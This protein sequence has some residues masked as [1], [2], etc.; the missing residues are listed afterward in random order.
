MHC[1]SM[2]RMSVNVESVKSF[3][4]TYWCKYP[5]GSSYRQFQAKECT[6]KRS[7]EMKISDFNG[8]SSHIFKEYE[9]HD[10]FA[11]SWWFSTGKSRN[12]YLFCLNFGC[13]SNGKYFWYLCVWFHLWTNKTHPNTRK[14]LHTAKP[15]REW[16]RA[17]PTD[18]R[19]CFIIGRI[20][21]THIVPS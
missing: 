9:F 2:G 17:R 13:K 10:Y 7:A 6:A 21:S 4:P 11:A 3:A 5:N 19:I 15:K 1:E 20:S 14:Q 8:H 12:V 16:V 18:M